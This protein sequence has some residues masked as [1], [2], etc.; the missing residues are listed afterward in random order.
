[1]I[2]KPWEV[3]PHAQKVATRYSLNSCGGRSAVSAILVYTP[4]ECAD[5]ENL[6]RVSSAIV[7]VAT[8]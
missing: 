5:C 6:S 1:M 2:R 8:G 4:R 7:Q 3:D